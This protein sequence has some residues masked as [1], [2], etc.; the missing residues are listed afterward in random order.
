[1]IEIRNLTKKFGRRTIFEE[2]NMTLES[3]KIYG[4][5]GENGIGK[6]VFFKTMT[7]LLSPNAGEVICN[8]KRIGADTDYMENLG[9]MDG[10]VNFIN[11]LSGLENLKMLASVRAVIS[12]KEIRAFMEKFGLS[13][14]DTTKVK[15]YSMGM[16]QKLSIIQAVMEDPAI[17]IFDE[18]FN[19]LD[20]KS[21]Q[22]VKQYILNLKN[23][24][25]TVLMTS[26]ILNDIEEIADIVYEFD[27]GHIYQK[28]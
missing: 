18:P 12:E 27:N 22:F 15:D 5:V 14:D 10:S 7:G 11:Y 4:F 20:K 9:Y 13:P 3:G 16:R 1:M 23:T 17:M 24:Q 26:H 19:G 8:G 6:S 28:E 21:V 2:V 25:K